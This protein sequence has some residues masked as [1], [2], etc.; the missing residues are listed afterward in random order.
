M[1]P[2]FDLLPLFNKSH[3]NPIHCFA[4][5]PKFLVGVP[6]GYLFKFSSWPVS[7]SQIVITIGIEARH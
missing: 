5:N 1:D 2:S 6:L 3:L 7:N 4:M